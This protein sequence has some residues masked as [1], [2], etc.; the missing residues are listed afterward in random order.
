MVTVS[1]PMSTTARRFTIPTRSTL[2]PTG[3]GDSCDICPGIYDP[4]QDDEENNGF[5]D[6]CCCEVRGDVDHNGSVNVSDITYLVA[7][8]FGGTASAGLSG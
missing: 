6:N 5:G 8:L 2:T 7:W 1:V 4:W 3:F